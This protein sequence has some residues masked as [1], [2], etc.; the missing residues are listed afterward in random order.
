MTDEELR[1]AL[2]RAIERV[3]LYRRPNAIFCNPKHYEEIN[4]EFG[5]DFKVI[6]SEAVEPD[7]CYLIDRKQ[8]EQFGGELL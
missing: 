1:I 8:I 5:E 6:A 4:K 7:K 2:K 3:D